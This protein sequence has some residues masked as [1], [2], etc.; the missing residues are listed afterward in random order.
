MIASRLHPLLDPATRLYWASLLVALVLAVLIAAWGEPV[1]LL[2]LLLALATLDFTR[3]R[4]VAFRPFAN[5]IRK[6][7]SFEEADGQLSL[8]APGA[9]SL[10]TDVTV[11]RR[12]RHKTTRRSNAR[13]W[14]Y[15][16]PLPLLEIARA[17]AKS[18]RPDV[19]TS[20]WL[21][22]AGRNESL[23][24]YLTQCLRQ[25]EQQPSSLHAIRA[26]FEIIEFLR[27]AD[28]S[29]HESKEALFEAV[30]AQAARGVDVVKKVAQG[31]YPPLQS[32]LAAID[33]KTLKLR[34]IPA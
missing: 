18:D 10:R 6:A 32:R 29:E 23:A 9:D 25:A 11:D 22:Q 12:S 26:A 1:A 21:W 19:I 5:L 15:A 17:A 30:A 27:A 24:P 33:P 34:K 28:M 3:T 31:N 16:Q 7:P 2:P 13:Q 20:A 8:F 4:K 14:K